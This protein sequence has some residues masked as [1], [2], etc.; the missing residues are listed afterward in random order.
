MSTQMQ[1]RG[2]TTAEN[3]LFT[4]AQRE[5]TVDTD[6]NTLIAHDG[7]TAGGFPLATEEAVSD[8]TFY[9]NDD[10]AGGSAANAYILAPKANTNT[11]TA[12]LDG[13]QLGFT[14]ANANT[15]PS[16]ANFQGLGVKNLKYRDGTD[17]AA[18][19]ISGRVNLVYDAVSGWLEI[20]RKAASP[21]PQIRTISGTVAANAMT[22]KLIAPATID[23]RS[24]TLGSGTINSRSVTSDLT[25]VVP[26]GATLGTTNGVANR[27]VLVAI[28]NAGTPELAVINFQSGQSFDETTLISTTAISAASSSASTYYSTVARAGV[29]FRVLGF[30]D[31]TQ[32]IAGTWAASPSE[33]QGQG[34][35]NIIGVP[36]I[37]GSTQ[38]STSG[39]SIDFTGIPTWAKR[40]TLSLAG[41][42][43]NGTANMQIQIGDSGGVEVAGYAGTSSLLD[44]ATS[45][46]ASTTGFSLRNS[47]AA[48][49]VHGQI[50]LTNVGGDLWAA[51]GVFSNS[52]VNAT[53]LSAGSKTLSATLDRVRLTT[54]TGVDTFDAGSV[55]VL[56]EG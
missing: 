13:I 12:Y 48:A 45:V 55:S 19:D 26:A 56:Y 23:F 30:V 2:G 39:T 8:G 38:L 1:L 29:P 40:I 21:L 22:L 49:V 41:V 17:P 27:L 53:M 16:T 24:T 15:G 33:V 50:V 54:S 18:G 44:S 51:S 9:F 25:L 32:T 6:K 4:G 42:S 5:I 36:R 37:G 20:Q 34:G 47:T 43:T 31:S 28:D 10:T 52:G 7:I 11:P 3:L 46:A 35:Q 14:T